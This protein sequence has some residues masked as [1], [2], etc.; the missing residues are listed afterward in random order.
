M[1]VVVLFVVDGRGAAR[2][3]ISVVD[4]GVRRSYDDLFYTCFLIIQLSIVAVIHELI[5][6]LPY[7]IGGRC[8][9][10]PSLV[11]QAL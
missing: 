10:P 8:G 5:V 2:I 7:T 1:R 3:S 6:V 4:N 11:V 9:S